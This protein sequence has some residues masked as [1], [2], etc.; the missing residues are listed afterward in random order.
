MT[1][2]SSC[3]CINFK[4]KDFV[5]SLNVD[6]IS[7]PQPEEVETTIPS[8][9]AEVSKFA[10]REAREMAIKLNYRP[11]LVTAQ[12][13]GSRRAARETAFYNIL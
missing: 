9:V 11:K 13:F 8:T 7:I 5:F 1:Q 4:I 12:K 2:V 10:T 6:S 3:S